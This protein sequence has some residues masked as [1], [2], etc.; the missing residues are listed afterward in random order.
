VEL[1]G[2]KVCLVNLVRLVELVLLAA[3]VPRDRPDKQ[4]MRDRQ[5]YLAP[6]D[7]LVYRGNKEPPV[8]LELQVRQALMD[9]QVPMALLVRP[10]VWD[11]LVLRELRDLRDLLEL[12]AVLALV[13]ASAHRAALDQPGRLDLLVASE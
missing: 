8:C 1:L 6:P 11:R 5:D 13:E 4:A 3:A 2:R 9:F 7:P 12:L 10:V